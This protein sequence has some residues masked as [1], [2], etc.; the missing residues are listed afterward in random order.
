MTNPK[1]FI[2]S[3]FYSLFKP[4][5]VKG[6]SNHY[7]TFTVNLVKIIEKKLIKEYDSMD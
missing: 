2:S 3:C 4:V 7:Q 6:V 1:F 5:C